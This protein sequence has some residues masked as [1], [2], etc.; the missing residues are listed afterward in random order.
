MPITSAVCRVLSAG[1]S[2]RE[3]VRELLQRDLKAEF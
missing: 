3:A 2:P 1:V